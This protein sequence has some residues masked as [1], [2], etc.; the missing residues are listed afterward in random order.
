MK[1]EPFLASSSIIGILAQRLVRK[2]CPACK[3]KYAP[4]KEALKDI[5]LRSA[6]E[7]NFY[8]GKGCAKC[9]NTGYKGRIGIYELLVPDDKIRNA[10]ISKAPAEEIK[11]IAVAAGM[12]TLMEDGIA[13][14]KEGLTTV[15]EILRVTRE[16]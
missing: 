3:E 16:E 1:V 7:L 2:I 4:T 6:E 15:E 8:K 5:G 12:T 9:L 13:K 11:K 10:I 14:V